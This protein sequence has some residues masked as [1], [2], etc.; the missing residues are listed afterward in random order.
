[1]GAGFNEDT[2]V[3]I[4]VILT[5]TR[6]GYKY[7]SL[8]NTPDAVSKIEK[9]TVRETPPP[10]GASTAIDK[11][12]NIFTGIFFD[13]LKR[14]NPQAD[15]GAIK[16]HFNHVQTCLDNDDLGKE[17]YNLL[18]SPADIKLI[19]FEDFFRNTSYSFPTLFCFTIE[20]LKPF[21]RLYSGIRCS[22]F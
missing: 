1:M 7:L 9:L 5:L 21:I 15:E 17:F 19:D 18:T 6:L 12:T 2:R 20:F 22:M 4:P 16:K 8:K 14:L 11:K 13:A 3:K 10:Y